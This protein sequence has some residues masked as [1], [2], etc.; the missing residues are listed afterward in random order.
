V[1][2]QQQLQGMCVEVETANSKG[3][4]RQLFQKVKSMTQTFQPRL[5]CISDWRK[6]MH[7]KA[8]EMTEAAQIRD[9]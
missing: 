7:S 6:L 3:N 9:R 4:S 5:Q 1:D 8:D 2:E